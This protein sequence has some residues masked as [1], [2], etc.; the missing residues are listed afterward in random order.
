MAIVGNQLIDDDTGHVVHEYA[1]VVRVEI[2]T[3]KEVT[4]DFGKTVVEPAGARYSLSLDNVMTIYQ[5][6]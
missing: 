3:V 1:R 2:P 4:A 5:P 6:R